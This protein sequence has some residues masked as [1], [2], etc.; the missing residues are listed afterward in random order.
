MPGIF[1]LCQCPKNGL[2]E[3]DSIYLDFVFTVFVTSALGIYLNGYL[4]PQ[5]IQNTNIIPRQVILGLC[6]ASLQ[7]FGVGCLLNKPKKDCS[8]ICLFFVLSR[9]IIMKR[10]VSVAFFDRKFKF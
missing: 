8:R 2:S 9:L 6:Y 1:H 10:L 3:Y 7:I 4:N 5:L